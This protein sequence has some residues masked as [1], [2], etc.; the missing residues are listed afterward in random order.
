MRAATKVREALAVREAYV[1][2]GLTYATPCSSDGTR[3]RKVSRRALCA[4]ERASAIETLNSHRFADTA[5]PH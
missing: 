3:P 4:N 5:V 1:A 2:L